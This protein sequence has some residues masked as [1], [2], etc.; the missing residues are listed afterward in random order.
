MIEDI[1][2]AIC[3]VVLILVIMYFL[4][5]DLFEQYFLMNIS[6]YKNNIKSDVDSIKIMRF[7][8]KTL[9]ELISNSQTSLMKLLLLSQKELCANKSAVIT[10]IQT[11]IKEAR[12]KSMAELNNLCTEESLNYAKTSMFTENS[13]EL[14]NNPVYG[15]IHYNAATSQLAKDLF[16]L[17]S[18]AI[19]KYFCKSGK[20]DIDMLEKYL[21]AMINDLCSHESN[22]IDLANINSNYLLRKPFTYLS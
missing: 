8:D 9:D 7:N 2:S 21:I 12:E 17:Y 4:M 15:A 19:T 10:M 18:Y 22:V 1:K 20:F 6:M 14:K 3:I 11:Y 5:P 16:N 13:T